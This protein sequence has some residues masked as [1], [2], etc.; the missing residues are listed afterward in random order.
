MNAETISQDNA[1]RPMA[2]LD[3]GSLT[4]RYNDLAVG[5][6]LRIERVSNITQFKQ[7]L[8]RRQLEE[9]KDYRA[10]QKG[11]HCYIKRLSANLM[12]W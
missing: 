12:T 8:S 7:A 5:Q 4:E 1:P 11:K 9:G 3:Y 2:R 10:Y 6:V